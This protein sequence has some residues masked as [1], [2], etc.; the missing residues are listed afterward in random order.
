MA[1]QNSSFIRFRKRG[2]DIHQNNLP[3]N[4]RAD[5]TNHY[6]GLVRFGE[7]ADVRWQFGFKTAARSDYDLDARTAAAAA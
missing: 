6:I 2:V 4:Q 3:S 5:L 7:K 1:E